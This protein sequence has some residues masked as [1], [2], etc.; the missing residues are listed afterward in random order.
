MRTCVALSES[1]AA[2][3]SVGG[4]EL[5]MSMRQGLLRQLP[6]FEEAVSEDPSSSRSLLRFA[7]GVRG[8]A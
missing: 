8:A 3:S 5:V 4:M 6:A 1:L 7:V 2:P